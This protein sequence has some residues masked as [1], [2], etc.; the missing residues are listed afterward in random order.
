MMYWYGGP[1]MNGW[2]VA[3]MAIGMG[4][5]L[6]LLIVGI[7]VLVR[8]LGRTQTHPVMP[9]PHASAP[10]YTAPH[11]TAAQILA[12]RFARGEIDEEEYRRRLDT[13]NRP[14]Q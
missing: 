7:V 1:A 13:I 9:P 3:M 4:L 5:L 14:A 12:E 11:Y 2:G 8:Y 6:I 10:H